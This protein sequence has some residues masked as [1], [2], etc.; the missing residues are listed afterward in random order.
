M[1]VSEIPP[2]ESG[3]AR[4]ADRLVRG[5]RDRGHV[6]DVVSC[7][8]VPRWVFGEFRITGFAA[9]WP[10][11]Q[12]ALPSYDVVNLHG[13]VPTL[14][15]VFLLL[16]RS[17]PRRRRPAIVY[18][19]HS[20]IDIDGWD[21]ACSIYNRLHERLTHDVDRIVVTTEGYR[22]R[23]KANGR[24]RVEVIPWGVECERFCASPR[25]PPAE[26]L[27]RVLFV[28]QMR[29]YKGVGHLL[30]AVAG[31]PELVTTL[32]GDGIE[33]DR[34]RMEAESLGA[35]NVTFLGRV[36][37]ETLNELYGS[38]DV[39]VLP[40]VSR[41][42]A[43]GLVLLEGMA[44]GCVPVASDLPGVRDVAGPT[45]LLVEPGDEDGLRGA[46]LALCGDRERLRRLAAASVERV[47]SLSWD[48][49]VDRYE[50]VLATYALHA[51]Q[52][53][54]S[55]ALPSGWPAPEEVLADLRSRAGA[56]WASMLLFD[57][58]RATRARAG[59][60]RIKLDDLGD[61]G[62]EIARYAARTGRPLVLRGAD[63]PS[64]VRPWLLRKDVASA[65][66]V[67]I[68]APGGTVVVN[69][70]A[71]RA[72]DRFSERDVA[73]VLGALDSPISTL[74]EIA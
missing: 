60:G 43:F 20:D 66:S 68:A 2:I 28:G 62:P 59:W 7:L 51:R 42:E 1:V 56:D 34:Y 69:L 3:V 8:D 67:P 36:P 48:G 39:I 63:G 46:L 37:D 25:R 41:G 54:A 12:R 27:L 13:P 57:R 4:C 29:A 23:L 9:R 32:V 58:S 40:S 45:G 21:V 65:I 55:S 16:S 22:R 26:N 72:P 73:L 17:V 10:S 61:P 70:S 38:H 19:H 35:T 31:R 44:A 6:V 47:Q 5:L 15:D 14:S 64:A 71:A 11:V 52:R 24:R 53:R 30:R 49:V 18:T 33:L 74:S 50:E